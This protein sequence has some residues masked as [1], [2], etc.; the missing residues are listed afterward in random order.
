MAVAESRV[1]RISVRGRYHGSKRAISDDYV[2][3]DEILGKGCSGPIHLATSICDSK[4]RFA[5]KSFNLAT[6]KR[7]ERDHLKGELATFLCM[8]H[9]HVGRLVDIYENEQTVKLVMECIDGGELFTRITARKQFVESE[10]ADAMRQILLAVNYLHSH[11]IVHRDL[12]LENF[13]YDAK[14]SNHLKLIDFGFSKFFH[15]QGRLRS[16]CGTLAYVAPEVLNENYGSQCDLWSVGVIAFV[17]LSGTMPFYGTREKKV[18]NIIRGDYQMKPEVWNS[19]SCKSK[20]FVQGL[21]CSDP[22]IRLDAKRALAHPWIKEHRGDNAPTPPP[23]HVIDALSSWKSAPKLQRAC[24][25]LMAWSLSQE[26]HAKFRDYFL[27][28]D[29]D[30]DGAICWEELRR[31]MDKRRIKTSKVDEVFRSF[32][33]SSNN[34]EINYSEFAAALMSNQVVEIQDDHLRATFRKFDKSNSGYISGKDFS[35]VVGFEYDGTKSSDL[36]L[37]ADTLEQDGRVDFH[38]FVQYVRSCSSRSSGSSG[39]Q[40]TKH[41]SHVQTIFAPRV[42]SSTSRPAKVMDANSIDQLTKDQ[43]RKALKQQQACCTLM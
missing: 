39:E 9:P 26:E 41:K 11:S 18:D 35:S 33:S 32:S 4:R 24:L 21:L 34:D 40:C 1:G 28:L 25:T 36:L 19:L 38:E 10:A 22:K 31:V 13:L 6:L 5:V 43:A 8:D 7:I 14:D 12:K 3:T 15:H 29:I 27:A 16:T 20:S 42:K 30:H 2:V 17:L 37:E 23:P